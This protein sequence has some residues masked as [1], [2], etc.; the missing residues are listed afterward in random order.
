MNNVQNKAGFTLIGRNPDVL[1]CIANLSS[2]EVFTPPELANKMLDLIEDAWAKDHGGKSIWEDSLV[3]ILDPF[4]KSGVFLREATSRFVKG[5]ESEMPDLQ[6]RVDHVLG[7]QVYGIGITSLTTLLSRRS[8]YCSK[9]ANSQHSITKIFDN[10]DGNIWFDRV[11]HEWISATNFIDTADSTGKS[12]R[13]GTNGK[14]KYCGA[15]QIVFDRNS[16]LETH[17]Y[18]FIHT[19][20]IKTKLNQLFGG[21]MQFDVVIGNPP[22]QM[23]DAAGGG[24]DSSIYHLFVNMAKQLDPRYL[25]MVI[26]SRWMGGATRGVGDFNGFRDRMLNDGHIRNLVD[27][28]NSKE[29]FPGVD[30]KGGVCYFLW[31]SSHQGEASVTSIREGIESEAN[32][33]LNEYD[34]F[35][36]DHMAIQILHKIQAKNE[37][38]IIEI[39]TADTPFGI[40]SN[41]MQHH[42]NKRQKDVALYYSRNG[43]RDIGFIEESSIVKNAGLINKWKVLTPGA[44]SDGGQKIPDIV[45][46]KP[47][48][49][50]PPAVCTQTFLAFFID[51]EE[52]ATSLESYYRTKF[53]RFL[54][55]L[56]KIT[57][58]GFRSTYEFV[59]QQKWNQ[60]WNDEKLYKKYDLTAGEREYIE[61]VI[62]PM[63]NLSEAQDD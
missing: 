42:P 20:D 26:P 27:F 60:E 39:L 11:E 25:S 21:N 52:E 43:K 51:S 7:N 19:D 41:F 10:G 16:A 53:F 55:S 54:V 48:I 2:D 23:T 31:D 35:V 28:P 15:P 59:P 37:K 9:Y 63:N 8:L 36:R 40:A 56:R 49:C 13:K 17:A 58:N 6:E 18:A 3:K 44:G 4:T 33:K 50:P 1:T 12:I 32:R 29:V 46:G 34:V 61:S 57:Q 47:W 22:Y 30:V 62:R 24:V 14:C 45:L 38:S 5:L